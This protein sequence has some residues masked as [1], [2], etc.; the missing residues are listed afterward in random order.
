MIFRNISFKIKK[1]IRIVF[2]A[3]NIYFCIWLWL[4]TCKR[5]LFVLF[6]WLLW[7][8]ELNNLPFFGQ[9]TNSTPEKR[10]TPHGNNMAK[11]LSCM[12]LSRQLWAAV[13][14]QSSKLWQMLWLWMWSKRQ[15]SGTSRASLWNCPSKIG[16]KNNDY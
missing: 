4:S 10:S 7:E 12:V 3:I 5:K 11:L 16:N 2:S 13:L 9:Q 8:E 1:D 6:I 15:C 14:F